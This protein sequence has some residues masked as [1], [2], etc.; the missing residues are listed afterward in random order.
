MKRNLDSSI[1]QKIDEASLKELMP[2]FNPE[3]LWQ[4]V[5][6]KVQPRRNRV[7]PWRRATYAGSL[8]AG[9]L[10]A[11]FFLFRDT[12]DA[13]PARPLEPTEQVTRVSPPPP[14]ALPAPATTRPE[15]PA[16]STAPATIPAPSHTAAAPSLAQ[17]PVT[18]PTKRTAPQALPD[19]VVAAAPTTPEPQPQP[20]SP[21][22]AG[23]RPS[24]PVHFLD[25][26]NED[27]DIILQPAATADEDKSLV[28]SIK[29]AGKKRRAAYQTAPEA[30]STLALRGLLR[31]F[32][33]HKKDN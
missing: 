30:N 13:G 15:P 14:S 11:W 31:S 6:E 3:A 9:I 27:K 18:T 22:L 8:A 1:R 5:S 2:G 33:P 16:P 19:P 10:L 20:V 12:R 32:G 28:Q 23:A 29:A 17:Q 24:R 7:I 26:N 4:Q 21:A 25:I